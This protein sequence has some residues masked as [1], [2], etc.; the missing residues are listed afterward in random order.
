[1]T[2]ARWAIDAVGCMH[3]HRNFQMGA[4]PIRLEPQ[5]PLSRVC[6]AAC[7]REFSGECPPNILN[8][9]K[10]VR[11]AVRSELVSAWQFPVLQGFCRE[12][13]ELSRLSEA[14]TSQNTRETAIAASQF[15]GNR[16]GK[17]DH[18]NRERCK[19]KDHVIGVQNHATATHQ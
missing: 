15:P 17:N 5:V 10:L 6:P 1:M 11:D 2:S 8:F 19:N 12:I 9:R 18:A 4:G 14:M 13:R 3:C 16:T 7:A